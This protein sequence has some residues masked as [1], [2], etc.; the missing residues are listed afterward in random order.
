M[1]GNHGDAI[2]Q[3]VQAARSRKPDVVFDVLVTVPPGIEGSAERAATGD[4]A[5]VARAIVAQGVP[6]ERVRLT[7]RPEPGAEPRD[8][9]VFVR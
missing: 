6:P 7:A 2:R 9:R 1:P 3:A 4:A 5:A 8:I